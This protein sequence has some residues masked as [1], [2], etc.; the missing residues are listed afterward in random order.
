ME[1]KR[2]ST[3]TSWVRSGQERRGCV[4]FALACRIKCS[5]VGESGRPA[6]YVARDVSRAGMFIKQLAA[7]LGA[8]LHLSVQVQAS[9]PA[10]VLW[11]EVRRVV[12]D[13]SAV[14]FS[15]GQAPAIRAL[16][17][18]LEAVTLRNLRAS[19]RHDQAE[20]VRLGRYYEETGRRGDAI[21]I[22]L[23]TLAHEAFDLE[24]HEHVAC[25]LFGASQELGSEK[26]LAT[27]RTVVR[28]G[29][30]IGQSS[31]LEGIMRSLA[32]MDGRVTAPETALSTADSSG[33]GGPRPFTG[34][35]TPNA[36]R[37]LD[38]W[39]KRSTET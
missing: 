4:R 17:R 38:N 36:A 11:A 28:R 22:Y 31:T 10:V 39:G 27:L 16:E 1:R 19:P 6:I 5:V 18:E 25:L 14:G 24:L 35:S 13:G 23:K 12:A 32:Q 9:A 20:W 33:E 3:L 30:G 29:L 34:E 8:R 21:T 2:R 26:L 15:E 7:P 37:A